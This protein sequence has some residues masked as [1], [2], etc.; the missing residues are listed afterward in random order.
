M[1]RRVLTWLA[2]LALAAGAVVGSNAFSIRNRL[3]G[4]ALPAPVSPVTSRVA[5]R[6]MTSGLPERTALRSAPWWQTV[7]DLEGTGSTTSVPFTIDSKAFDWRVT[8]SCAAGHLRVQATAEPQPLI[9]ADCP[10]G[11]GH[12]DRRGPTRLQVTAE[13][14]WRLEVAQRIDT[15]LVEP[16]LAAMKAPGT[17]ALATGAFYKLDKVGAGKVTIYDQ[18]DGGY[19]VRLDDF[20]VSPTTALQ[21]RLSTAGAPRTSAEY[22]KSR[23]QLLTEIDVTA[24]SLNFIVPA[25]V[26]PRRFGSVVVWCPATASAYAAASL[27]A[28]P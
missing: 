7:A 22:L 23:S 26:D 25:G 11:V 5:N 21:L 12:G 6:S 20:W 15:P 14:P 4:S 9:D 1:G 2:V 24:G 13:G 10:S 16:L 17:K 28:A 8:W 3:L 19:S 18:A 27:R